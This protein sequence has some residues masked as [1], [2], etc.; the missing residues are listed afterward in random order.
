MYNC[1]YANHFERGF[2]WV[3]NYEARLY[4]IVMH[5]Q[6]TTQWLLTLTTTQWTC[7]IV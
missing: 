1:V 4:W 2:T 3:F 6:W 7:R 5:A